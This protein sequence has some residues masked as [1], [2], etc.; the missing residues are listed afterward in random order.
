M[1]WR[2]RLREFVVAG[3]FYVTES[4]YVKSQFFATRLRQQHARGACGNETRSC[5]VIYFVPNVK[6][7]TYI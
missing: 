5:I 3:L 4:T 7:P 1:T 6:A 2:S